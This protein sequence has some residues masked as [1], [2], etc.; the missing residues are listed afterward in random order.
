[1]T[2]ITAVILEL[3]HALKPRTE[4]RGAF[5]RSRP[6]ALGRPFGDSE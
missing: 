4:V 2:W 6:N 1:M 5:I 3:I